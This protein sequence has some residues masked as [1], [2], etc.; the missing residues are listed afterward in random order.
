MLVLLSKED[1]I[2]FLEKQVQMWRGVCYKPNL[3]A[4][5]FDPKTVD[6]KKLAEDGY[7]DD[8]ISWIAGVALNALGDKLEEVKNS[9]TFK[10]KKI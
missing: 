3:N 4:F 5:E 7:Y 2:D 1:T 6:P 9:P 10:D 8:R